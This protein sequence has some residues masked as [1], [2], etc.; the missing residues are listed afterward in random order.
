MLQKMRYPWLWAFSLLGIGFYVVA[1]I[2]LG[3]LGGKWLDAKFGTAIGWTI[4]G[5]L[6]GINAA[7]YGTY[8][9]LRPFIRNISK[10]GDNKKENKDNQ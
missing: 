1:A 4:A 9:M 7:V 5:L 10:N 3:L 2:I 6:L 8:N